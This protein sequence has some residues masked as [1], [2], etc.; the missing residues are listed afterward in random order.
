MLGPPRRSS[1]LSSVVRAQQVADILARNWPC[2]QPLSGLKIN[3]ASPSARSHMATTVDT[4]TKQ[5]GATSIT[6]IRSIPGATAERLA[7][8]QADAERLAD[9]RYEISRPPGR[10]E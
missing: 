2:R 3:A 8:G 7:H 4:T 6:A 10:H 1:A 9:L 5:A